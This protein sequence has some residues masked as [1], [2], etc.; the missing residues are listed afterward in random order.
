MVPVCAAHFQRAITAMQ[1]RILGLSVTDDIRKGVAALPV[2]AS[3]PRISL[4]AI[5]SREVIPR[6]E[7]LD[8]PN[9][10]RS[11]ASKEK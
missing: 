7:K 6:A 3:H 2:P 4:H 10:R 5:F 1:S 9:V 8:R 11:S